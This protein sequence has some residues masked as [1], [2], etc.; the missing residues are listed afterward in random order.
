VSAIVLGTLNRIAK[1]S[2]RSGGALQAKARLAIVRRFLRYKK[3][4]GII[5]TNPAFESIEQIQPT[6]LMKKVR[7]VKE[8]EP[9]WK[10]P[11]AFDKARGILGIDEHWRVVLCYGELKA[12]R[13]GLP[14]LFAAVDHPEMGNVLILLVG[15]PNA[16]TAELLNSSTGK[17]LRANGQIREIFGYVS[18]ECERTSFSASDAVWIGYPN[19][20]APS[21]VLEIARAAGVPI[22]ASNG[23]VIGSMVEQYELGSVVDVTDP[24]QTRCALSECFIRSNSRVKPNPT[25]LASYDS[26]MNNRGF[27]HRICDIIL[28]LENDDSA[29]L[30]VCN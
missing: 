2:T 24:K 7:Y 26:D 28:A 10:Y 21:G 8:I 17:R 30:A 11:M 5:T 23:G 27:G 19:F 4:R 3:L 20:R 15:T 14:Q 18:S 16:S 22:V 6:E 12:D 25:D 13:K 9:Q 29:E 1:N